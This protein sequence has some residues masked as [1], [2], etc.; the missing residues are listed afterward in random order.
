MKLDAGSG[1]NV[2][3]QRFFS[4]PFYFLFIF[5]VFTSLIQFFI[6]GGRLGSGSGSG[7]KSIST[8]RWDLHVLLPE[9]KSHVYNMTSHMSIIWQITWVV[10]SCLSH[11]YITA[12][13]CA[14]KLLYNQWNLKSTVKPVNAVT[15]IKRSPF[16]C[17]VIE[18]FIWIE[19]LLRGHLSNYKAMF[20]LF[21][22]WPLNTSLHLIACSSSCNN[23]YFMLLIHQCIKHFTC[24]M[25]HV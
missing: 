2:L 13:H 1:H 25:H 5:V 18:N 15:S 20:S 11:M 12:L 16:S 14:R 6:S 17:Y 19:P 8:D 9:Q 23:K 3:N 7:R 24:T 21:Q 4:N 10:C 22:R